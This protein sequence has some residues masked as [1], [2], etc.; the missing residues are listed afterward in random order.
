QLRKS[1]QV[2]S[3]AGRLQSFE[4]H[5]AETIVELRT[6]GGAVTRRLTVGTVVNCTGPS[7]DIAAIHLPLIAQLRDEGLISQ[8][9]LKLGLRIDAH[10]Q[11]IDGGGAPVDG[12]F[13]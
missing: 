10:Y 8:D 4:R 1:G 12:L 9:P 2:E 3:I 6:P 7:Y 11:V 13:Y 5:G